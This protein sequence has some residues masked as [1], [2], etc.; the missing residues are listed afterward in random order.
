MLWLSC[1][2][3]SSGTTEEVAVW[4]RRVA[5][6]L[7]FTVDDAA[8]EALETDNLALQTMSTGKYVQARCPPRISAYMCILGAASACL[9]MC[10]AG[11]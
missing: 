4:K 11:Q 2:Y 3:R 7:Q 1:N 5:R 9:C 10:G 8:T 6:V